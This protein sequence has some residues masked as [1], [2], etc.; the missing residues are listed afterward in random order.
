[1]QKLEYPLKITTGKYEVISS[2][3]V[4]MIEEEVKFNLV[5]LIIRFKFLQDSGVSR[6]LGEISGNELII[7]LFNNN[8]VLGEGVVS[9]VEIG[10]L[11]GRKLFCT[12][13][14]NT[15]GQDQKQFNYTFMLSE[16]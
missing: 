10:T 1:M 8:N 13:I 4:H 14:V 16:G 6:Y 15:F 7:N 5:N 2:G 3:V 9:P 11:G 12:W